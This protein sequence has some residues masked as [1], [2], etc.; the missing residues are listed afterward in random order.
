[1]VYAEYQDLTSRPYSQDTTLSRHQCESFVQSHKDELNYI[2][3]TKSETGNWKQ[4]GRGYFKTAF[5]HPESP[6][7]VI[8]IPN[9]ESWHND[10]D[11]KTGFSNIQ[12]AKNIIYENKYKYIALP[13]S[14]LVAIKKGK[15][16]CQTKFEFA[17]NPPIDCKFLALAEFAD[18][19]KKAGFC[20][21]NIDRRWN[22]EFLKGSCEIGIYDLECRHY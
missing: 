8:K 20:D 17:E 14:H 13:D 2:Y 9:P 21:I 10:D 18:F 3:E 1:M 19:S 16:L 6:Q 4:I 22:A 12:H 11:L 7:I 5:T 15:I